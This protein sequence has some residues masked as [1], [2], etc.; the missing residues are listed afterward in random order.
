MRSR[1]LH[2]HGSMYTNT[3]TSVNSYP[4]NV[5]AMTWD[6]LE[7]AGSLQPFSSI[8]PTIIEN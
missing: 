6:I 3:G 7:A 1:T 4:V 8:K 2:Q 5:C